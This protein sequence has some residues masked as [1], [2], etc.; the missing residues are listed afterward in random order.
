[1]DERIEEEVRLSRSFCEANIN[2]TDQ[3]PSQVNMQKTLNK[4]LALE[5]SN[6]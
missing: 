5:I 3:N 6:M 4:I 1:M 2:L